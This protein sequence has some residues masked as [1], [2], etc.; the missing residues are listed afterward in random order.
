MSSFVPL[1]A[2][3][4]WQL[5]VVLS[6]LALCPA[7]TASTGPAAAPWHLPDWSYR[8]VVE[9]ITKDETATINTALVRLEAAPPLVADDGRDLRVLDQKGRPVKFHLV[10]EHGARRTDRIDWSRP[11]FIHLEISGEA[12]AFYFIYFGNPDAEQAFAEWEKRVGGL[13]LETRPNKNRQPAENFRQLQQFLSATPEVFGSGERRQINDPENPF[14]P[15]DFFI[16]TYKGFIYCPVSGNYAF[17]TDSD[18]SSFLLVDGRLVVQW[19][20]AH[21]PAGA[22]KYRGEMDLTAGVHRIEYYLVQS[23]G[24]ALARAGWQPPG[25]DEMCIIPPEA[26]LRELRTRTV[27]VSRRDSPVGTYFDCEIRQA[28]RFATDGPVVLRVA[29]RDLSS[30]LAGD[31]V[32]RC[33]DFGEDGVATEPEPVRTFVVRGEKRVSL[34]CMDSWGFENSWQ[35]LIATDPQTLPQVSLEV[36]IAPSEYI[37]EPGEPVRA[38]VGCAQQGWPDLEVTLHVDLA[39]GDGPVVGSWGDTLSLL[40]GRWER[41]AYQFAGMGCVPFDVGHIDA[42]LDYLGHRIVQRR[43]S[44]RWARDPQLVLSSAQDNLVD[45]HGSQVVLRLSDSPYVRSR[46]RLADRLRARQPVRILFVDDAL[47]GAT[48]D[49]YIGRFQ[50][51]LK[52]ATGGAAIT[53]VRVGEEMG[54]SRGYVPFQLMI[55][56]SRAAV[57][58]QPDLIVLAASLRDILRF[59]PVERYERALRAMVDRME[60]MAGSEVVLIAPPPLIGNP[61]FAQAYAIATKRVGLIKGLRVVDGYSEF[62]RSDGRAG[63]GQEGPQ[64]WR[65]FYRQPGSAVPVYHLAPTASGQRLL[66]DALWRVVFDDREPPTPGKGSHA[67]AERSGSRQAGV[68]GDSQEGAWH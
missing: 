4:A 28:F 35:R 37:V 49:G 51:M 6:V 40:Q 1:P 12:S 45:E 18:D 17:G 15:S 41:R 29:L 34:R 24:G 63:D 14:G 3:R 33:W 36:Q 2:F 21:N 19:P 52:S 30:S 59:E 39:P 44:V 60:A 57:E 26:F 62:M 67:A 56:G 31:I 23:G 53:C 65:R 25:A 8:Q 48:E 7:G 38:T 22:F 13:I 5:T 55:E 42:G 9:L 16:G 32:W 54:A 43:L 66:A 46:A 27:I 61:G 47:A 58:L 50:T 68:A 10:D 11:V 20:G 64:D